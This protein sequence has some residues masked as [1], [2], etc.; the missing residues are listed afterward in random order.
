MLGE[1]LD[2]I[3]APRRCEDGRPDVLGER[4]RGDA[5]RG[6]PAANQQRLLRLKIKPSIDTPPGLKPDGF[7]VLRGQY[8]SPSP[9]ALPEPFYVLRGVVVAMEARSA[10]R[11]GMP[12]DG[13]A[14]LNH[15]ATAR[16]GL[17]GVGR[18]HGY[19][20]LPGACCLESEDAQ[21]RAPARIMDALG[22]MVVLEHV[23]RLQ[24]LVIDHV[25]VAHQRERR[26]VVEVLSLAL[27]LSD[28]PWPAG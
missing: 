21:E 23:G 7:S 18:R 22:E 6:S 15:N 12:A 8:A 3:G 19:D 27:H 11:A 20:S 24:V 9:K 5:Q 1:R 25:V 26:L 16:T 17:A 13:Q 10:V 4:G 28:A 14:L 2:A